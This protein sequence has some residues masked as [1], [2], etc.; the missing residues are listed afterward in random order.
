VG[1]HVDLTLEKISHDR[2]GIVGEF[3]IADFANVFALDVADD[4]G[5]IVF[6]DEGIHFFG[7]RRAGEVED[8]GAGFEAGFGDDGLVGFDGDEDAGAVQAAHDGKEFGVLEI[9]FGDLGVR[10][11]GLGSDIDDGGALSVEDESAMDR[12]FG[13]ETHAFAIPGVRRE[14]DNAHDR[15][16]GVEGEGMALD[17]K[18]F[19]LGVS[20]GAVRF[21]KVGEM[22]DLQHAEIMSGEE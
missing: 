18:L 5:G 2:N 10:K 21:D 1:G 3:E 15:G 4:D 8:R 14:V 17:G 19:N 11:G 6:G 7:I 12:G 16:F 9:G 20:F 22:L 13:A